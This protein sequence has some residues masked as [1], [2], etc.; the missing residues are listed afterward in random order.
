MPIVAITRLRLCGFR[1]LVPFAWQSRLSARQA[2]RSPG[3][4]GGA[5]SADPLRLTFWTV[6]V[7][8]NEAA[9][10]AFRAAGDHQRV[11]PRLAGW[12]DE[13]S[14]AHWEQADASIPSPEE[15]LRRMVSGGRPSRLHHPSPDHTAGR[16]ATDGRPP[17]RG[18][19]LRPRGGS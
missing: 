6:T 10:R 18:A 8:E 15:V 17:V 14:V 7:W 9:M 11:M 12:C 4:L 16:I 19:P 1:Y 5:L 3:F 2:E 13:A